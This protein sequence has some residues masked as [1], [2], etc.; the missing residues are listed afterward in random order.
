MQRRRLVPVARKSTRQVHVPQV[1][2]VDRYVDVVVPVHQAVPQIQRLQRRVDVPQVR[3]CRK[4]VEVPVIKHVELESVEYVEKLV[5]APFTTL[6]PYVL[7]RI[8]RMSY[9]L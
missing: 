8:S 1:Q 3:L 9:R 7:Y 6:D 5:E 2:L 4:E